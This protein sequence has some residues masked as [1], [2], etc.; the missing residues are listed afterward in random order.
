MT[1]DQWKQKKLFLTLLDGQLRIEWEGKLSE[2]MLLKWQGD[3]RDANCFANFTS[4]LHT[5]GAVKEFAM[6]DF[7]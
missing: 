2:A 4:L 5:F 1:R 7:G 6:P 3:I